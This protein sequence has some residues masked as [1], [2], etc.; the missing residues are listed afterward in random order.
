MW[1]PW[2]SLAFHRLDRRRPDRRGRHSQ[3]PAGS[4][5]VPGGCG[6]SG[7]T[8][9]RWLFAYHHTRTTRGHRRQDQSHP[10]PFLARGENVAGGPGGLPRGPPGCRR[11]PGG[12]CPRSGPSPRNPGG[13]TTGCSGAGEGGEHPASGPPPPRG[14]AKHEPPQGG[15]GRPA[16]APEGQ[17]PERSGA[18]RTAA[19]TGR[20]ALQAAGRTTPPGRRPV[21]VWRPTR[22]GR[23]V[24]RRS[25]RPGI[26]RGIMVQDQ[27][28]LALMQG[29]SVPGTAT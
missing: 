26:R 27:G 9:I 5:Q 23:Q 21:H 2:R 16:P 15:G 1:T 13:V 11:Q 7:D 18:E 8:A 17:R 12:E 4:D 10:R 6:R 28:C 19:A 14:R 24:T 25:S 22:R 3:P 20:R 29:Q